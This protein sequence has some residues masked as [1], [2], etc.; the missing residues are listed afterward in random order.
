MG[1][2]D[3]Q[4]RLLKFWNS[5]VG[6]RKVEKKKV[7]SPEIGNIGRQLSDSRYSGSKSPGSM[8]QALLYVLCSRPYAHEPAIRDS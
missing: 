7:R 6:M 8:R 3:S 5:E 2:T 4:K 1:C